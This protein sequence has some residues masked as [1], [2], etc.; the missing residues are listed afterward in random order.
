MNLKIEDIIITLM[1][2]TVTVRLHEIIVIEEQLTSLSRDTRS[3]CSSNHSS[4]L[5]LIHS[6]SP[7]L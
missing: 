5:R 6:S 7:Q 4:S 2:Q 3:F 1:P